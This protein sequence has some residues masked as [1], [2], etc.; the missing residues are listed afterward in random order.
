MSLNFLFCSYVRLNLKY[1]APVGSICKKK[2]IYAVKKSSQVCRIR[3]F[4]SL[5]SNKRANLV[6]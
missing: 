4:N 5:K 1:A 3:G 2:D 6:N